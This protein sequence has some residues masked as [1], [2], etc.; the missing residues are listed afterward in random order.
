[1][2]EHG[3]PRLETGLALDPAREQVAESALREPDVAECVLLLLAAHLSFQLGDVGA[4]RDDDDAEELALAATAIEVGD[5]LG[6]GNLELGD[7]D[8]VCATGEDRK[9]TR[10]NSSHSQISYAV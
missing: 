2:P 8:Q 10:L 6:E 3:H 9:S 5:H 1:M 4:F 7:D